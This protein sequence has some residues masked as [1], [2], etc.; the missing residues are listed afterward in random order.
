MSRPEPITTA[1]EFVAERFPN[2]L[3]AWLGGSAAAGRTT[4]TSDLDVTVLIA[5]GEVHRESQTFKG[6]PVE[7]FVHTEFSVR[8]WVDLEEKERCP[9]TC[10]LQLCQRV[11]EAGPQPFSETELNMVRYAISDL[12]DDLAGGGSPAEMSAVV[13]EVWQRTA[14][15][16]LMSRRRWLGT[17]K[18][19]ARELKEIDVEDGT[20]IAEEFQESL[21]Q[22]VSGQPDQ[23]IALAR[24]VLEPLGG[25]LWDG[26]YLK[27]PPET[28]T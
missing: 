27:G 4:I 15:L 23:L 22:A 18:W 20:R 17:G 6:W 8:Y 12:L 24:K 11:F 2:A 9:T 1:R 5:K 10:R 28:Q 21:M 14:A 13:L 26:Y 3:Q 19:L 7:V 16:L 25:R